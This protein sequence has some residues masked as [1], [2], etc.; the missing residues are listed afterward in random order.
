M[1]F[2]PVK[3][4]DGAVAP[5]EYLPAAAGTYTVGQALK[6]TGGQL[7]ALTAAST[8]T[9]PYIGMAEMTAAA[10][11]ILPA[12]RVSDDAIYETT[13]SAA[14]ASA[15]IGSKLEVS[16]GGLEVDATAAGTFELV[17]LEGTA[18]GDVV[19]GRFV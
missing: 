8:T 15:V 19:R 4:N 6:V 11:D 5:L 17:S 18:K 14:A 2:V 7:A 1:S 10:G 3:T 9:P 16:S 12:I 13:L